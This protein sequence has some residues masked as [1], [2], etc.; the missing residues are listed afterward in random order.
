MATLSNGEKAVITLVVLAC[1]L[2][3]LLYV[4]LSAGE[5]NR[6]PAGAQLQLL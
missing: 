2:I 6:E 4:L 5:K 3:P 1:V